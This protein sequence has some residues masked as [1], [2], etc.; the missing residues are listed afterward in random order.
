[1]CVCVCGVKLKL[2]F[3]PRSLSHISNILSEGVNVSIICFKAIQ[4]LVNTYYNLIY[5]QHHLLLFC[6]TGAEETNHTVKHSTH[7]YQNICNNL[8]PAG[9]CHWG[10]TLRSKRYCVHDKMLWLGSA[11]TVFLRKDL[12]WVKRHVGICVTG[13]RPR[14]GGIP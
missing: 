8:L 4:F 7:L 14:A 11:Q 9:I 12:S 13:D 10:S 1:M 2:R 5:N 6:L 3:C